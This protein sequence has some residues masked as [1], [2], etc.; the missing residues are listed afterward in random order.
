[1]ERFK[2]FGYPNLVS[3][4]VLPN[5]LSR[6]TVGDVGAGSGK[7]LNDIVKA[8]GG[9]Y[10]AIDA[11]IEML[12]AQ[13][14]QGTEKL[15]QASILSL[16]F[17]NKSLD[18]LHTRFVLMNLPSNL[19]PLAIKELAR[20][21]K[22]NY[23][24]DFDWSTFEPVNKLTT[25]LISNARSFAKFA[26][27][28][29]E[30]GKKLKTLVL[31]A[32]ELKKNEVEERIFNDGPVLAYNELSDLAKTLAGV[33]SRFGLKEMA[34]N[35]SKI[36]ETIEEGKSPDLEQPFIRPNIVAVKF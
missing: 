1:M 14:T 29:L 22:E 4:A 24:L 25:E 23:V 8:R 20:V 11:K 6:L 15:A 17:T 7:T 5:D 26:R 9:D 18:I 16:P 13:K 34:Q 32:L 28:D 19:R 31:D 10:L 30:H 21:G 2:K 33:S 3:A 27:S 36:V 35:F 12:Q